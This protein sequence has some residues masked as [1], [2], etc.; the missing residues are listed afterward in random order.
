MNAPQCFVLY[1]LI[2]IGQFVHVHFRRETFYDS[3][4]MYIIVYLLGLS[5]WH[6]EISVLII[7]AVKIYLIFIESKS[8]I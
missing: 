2:Q 8:F 5:G 7:L 1:N 6:K 4:V 3:V